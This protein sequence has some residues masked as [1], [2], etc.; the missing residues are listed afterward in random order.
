LSVA[1]NLIEQCRQYGNTTNIIRR[2][3]CG[4]DLLRSGINAE[5]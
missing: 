5:V 4:G 2:Q 3:F 1:I